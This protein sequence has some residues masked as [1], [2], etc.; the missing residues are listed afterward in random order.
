MPGPGTMTNEND[1]KRN[2][3]DTVEQAGKWSEP[4]FRDG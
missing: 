1:L 2:W 3:I 4:G